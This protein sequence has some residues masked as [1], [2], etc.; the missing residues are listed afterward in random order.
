MNHEQCYVFY[1]DELALLCLVFE[2]NA[3]FVVII[4]N[5]NHFVSEYTDGLVYDF[6]KYSLL[7]TFG[8]ADF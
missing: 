3:C 1:L 7:T 4:K 8:F 5:G 6:F 2:M